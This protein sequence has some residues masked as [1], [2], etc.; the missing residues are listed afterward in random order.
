MLAATALQTCTVMRMSMRNRG[1]QPAG[2]RMR[3]SACCNIA[4]A[5][6]PADGAGIF[7]FGY[8]FYYYLFRS[9]MSGFMQTSFYF[10]APLLILTPALLLTCLCVR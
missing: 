4:D 5:L 10:G 6:L 3:H 8:C 1:S 2:G 9:D 7:V